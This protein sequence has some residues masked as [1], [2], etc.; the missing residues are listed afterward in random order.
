M[1]SAPSY[2]QNSGSTYDWRSGNRYSWYQDSLGTTHVRGS[3]GITGSMWRSTIDKDGQQ[4][5]TDSNGNMWRYNPD[6]GSYIN[7]GTGEMCF[8]RGAIRTCSGGS[9][10]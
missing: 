6:T 3:N 8:G 7:Y 5:G 4:R 9:S 2:E 1:Y 10:R